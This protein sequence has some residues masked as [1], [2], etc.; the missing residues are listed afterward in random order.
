MF[1]ERGR[2]FRIR[3]VARLCGAGEMDSRSGVAQSGSPGT[4]TGEHLELLEMLSLVHT[5]SPYT[6][7]TYSFFLTIKGTG[8]A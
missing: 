7:N 4:R 2:V 3:Y 5:M 8:N 6:Y 1:P